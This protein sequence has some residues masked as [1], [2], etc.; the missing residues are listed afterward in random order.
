[1]RNGLTLLLDHGGRAGLPLAAG[2]VGGYLA[3]DRGVRFL[4]TLLGLVLVV[5]LLSFGAVI[6]ARFALGR[7]HRLTP[8][9][10]KLRRRVILAAGAAA[11][12]VFA[13]LALFWAEQ[14]SP[15]T[16]LPEHELVAALGEDAARYRELDGALERMVGEVER[17]LSRAPSQGI[18]ASDDERALVD[19]WRG[20]YEAAFALDQLRIFY[21]DYY[22]LDPSIA[23]RSLHV[24]AFLLT[25][26][27]ELS[28]FEK[29]SRLGR[30]VGTNPDLIKLLDTPRPELGLPANAFGTF[31]EQLLGA[32]DQARVLAGR[33]Y[34]ELLQHGLDRRREAESLGFGP[35]WLRA[36]AHLDAIDT[37]NPIAQTA[38]MVRGDLQPLKRAVRRV[39]YPTVKGVAELMGDTR[40]RRVGWY[41][42]PPEQL[43]AA[44]LAL[45][46]GDV[47]VARKNWYLS[48]VGLPG[49]WPHAMLYLGAPEKLATLD[50]PEVRAWIESEL[51]EPLDLPS[52]LARRFPRS[53]AEYAGGE[54][55]VLIEAISEGVVFNTLGHAAGDYLAALR[56][57]LSKRA[58][59][60][61]I[62]E[63]FAQLGKPYDFDFDFVTDHA[64]VCTELV[65]RA[66]RPAQDKTGLELAPIPVA[67]RLTLPANELVRQWDA[68]T[69][70]LD[71]VY[72]IDANERA[73]ATFVSDEAALRGTWRR[74]KWDVALE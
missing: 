60:Q 66:Y 53:W 50:D 15:L 14:P 13:R 65:W 41:L 42:I 61:A 33:G 1:M 47:L 59:A 70:E 52:Y 7:A 72:F 68:G 49:F 18:L 12:V 74:T 48:N 26:A 22:R 56:P 69:A 73:R 3:A 27:A 17:R 63:A 2:L 19:L 32:R 64:L 29:A 24:R 36:E 39:W 67:G 4:P 16:T 43:A 8:A 57:R 55:L 71:F 25:F 10:L 30:A 5:L 31:R 51:G 62:A 44:E 54:A 11:L 21:E 28:L 37:I 9:G 6:A 45:E 20:I 35:I 46:P 38:G 34:L 23:Q 40:V 58:K